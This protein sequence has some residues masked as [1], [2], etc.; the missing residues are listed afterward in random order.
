ML[1]LN[2]GF[3]ALE[4]G[5]VAAFAAETV[6][7]GDLNLIVLAVQDGG[8]GLGGQVLEGSVQVEAELLPQACEQA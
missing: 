6:A 5:G 4:P 8:A 7:I 2:V 1:A 3:H